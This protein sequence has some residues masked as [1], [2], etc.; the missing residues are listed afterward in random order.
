M[1]PVARLRR[2]RD[3]CKAKASERA[4]QL[5]ESRKA[6]ARDRQRLAELQAQVAALEDQLEREKKAPRGP[7]Q[8]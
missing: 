3:R 2:S 6:K 5:R 1:H 7:A 8:P 4:E